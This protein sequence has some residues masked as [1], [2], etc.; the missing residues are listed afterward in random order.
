MFH[1]SFVVDTVVNSPMVMCIYVF[2]VH[3]DIEAYYYYS[4][5]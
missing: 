2:F 3:V 4:L 5:I 1:W